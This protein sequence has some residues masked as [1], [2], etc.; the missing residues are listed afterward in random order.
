M[1]RAC[2]RVM[3][4]PR[5]PRI[6]AAVL[7]VTA[8][9]TALYWWSYF[10]GGQ[11]RVVDARWYSA[12]EDSFP[13]ADAWMALCCAIAGIG[14]WSGRVWAARVGLLAGSALI[15]LACMDITFNVENGLYAMLATSGPMRFEAMVN[16]WSLVLGT[17][18]II[19]CWRRAA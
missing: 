5:A 14:L 13:I 18:T 17:G 9:V 15:Y 11:V 7:L 16:L 1:L 8:L 10:T 3:S 2:D 12:F 6:L 19:L 4:M